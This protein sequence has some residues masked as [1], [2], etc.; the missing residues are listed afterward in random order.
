MD[1]D[2]QFIRIFSGNQTVQERRH[3][4][5]LEYIQS[6]AA[7]YERQRQARLAEKVREAREVW[8]LAENAEREARLRYI[9]A[10]A[11]YDVRILDGKP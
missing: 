9:E 1:F 6:E 5:D 11:A 8:R 3:A 7:H 10:I 4:V 2:T